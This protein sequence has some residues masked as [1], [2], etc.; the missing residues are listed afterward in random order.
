MAGREFRV[1]GTSFC[2]QNVVWF[3]ERV[4]LHVAAANLTP[5]SPFYQRVPLLKGIEAATA[6][7]FETRHLVDL[8][9]GDPVVQK[10]MAAVVLESNMVRTVD[11]LASPHEY[12]SLF[13]VGGIHFI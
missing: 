5:H 13:T 4:L 3:D 7:E 1:D 8:S 12:L 2:C 11:L 6:T 9:E 10:A